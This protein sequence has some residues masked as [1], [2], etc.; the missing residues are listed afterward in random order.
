MKIV[1]H[2]FLSEERARA[3]A[4]D[5]NRPENIYQDCQGVESNLSDPE[6][7]TVTVLDHE[8][9]DGPDIQLVSHWAGEIE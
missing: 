6:Y 5:L 9:F 7:W 1:K 3:F 4:K 2:Q 8:L